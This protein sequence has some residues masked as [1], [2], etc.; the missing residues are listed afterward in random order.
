[1]ANKLLI[2]A[3]VIGLMF[4]YTQTGIADITSTLRPTADGGDDSANWLNTGGTACNATDCYL[5]VDESSGSSCTDSDGDTS[6]I[7][8]STEGA[9]QTF[10]VNISSIP[11]GATISQVDITV[12]Q[13]RVGSAPPNK[14]QTRKCVD[15]V[16]S[17]F[18]TDNAAAGNY[19]EVAQSHTGLSL[20]KTA[21]TD[22]EVGVSIMGT[23]S[24]V[25]RISQ[26]SAIV[27]YTIPGEPAAVETRSGGG[28][29]SPT[30]IIFS[31]TAYPGATLGVYLAREEWGVLQQALIDGEFN[32]END[33]SFQ[34]EIISPVE[35][36]RVYVLR[37]KDKDG[38]EGRSKVF[39]YDT[40]FNRVINQ[41]NIFFAPTINLSKPAVSRGELLLIS[42][43]AAPGN[44]VES[45]FDGKVTGEVKA[46]EGG[47]YR[48]LIDT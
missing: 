21:T 48:I 32:A 14:F 9:N 27:T 43:Y 46:E 41:E 45:I 8:S 31:G 4:L 20:L 42:G 6:F 17:N 3:V 33:G 1:M 35:E 22:L 13:K 23:N 11:D 16:C 37:I 38:K 28:G 29:N 40:K 47:L 7:E 30:K 19:A 18:G 44:K 39:T 12:C 10:D 34:K 2:L 5:E 26:I 36:R 25:V 24:K 15:G